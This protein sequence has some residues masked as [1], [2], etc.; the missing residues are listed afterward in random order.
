M[1]PGETQDGTVRLSPPSGGR[2]EVHA[3]QAV[4]SRYGWLPPR[5]PCFAGVEIRFAKRARAQRLM[6]DNGVAV[7]ESCGE[8]FVGAQHT[9]GF[10][11]RVAD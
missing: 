7:Q 5:R 1:P 2:I 4:E 3:A 10:I 9:N 11:L 6:E 8:W